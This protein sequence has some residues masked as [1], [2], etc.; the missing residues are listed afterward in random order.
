[1]A[2]TEAARHDLYAYF[3]ET[4]GEQRA[5]TLMDLLSPAD[6]ATKQDVEILRNQL[7]ATLERTLR[8]QL[9]ATFAFYGIFM[10][11]A[12]GLAQAIN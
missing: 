1:V 6:V 4:M 5:A 8:T 10:S 2:V 11:I 3:Q 9:M 7:T 12:V